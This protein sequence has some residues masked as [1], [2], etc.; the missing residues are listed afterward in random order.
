[1]LAGNDERILS[2]ATDDQ[3]KPIFS[4]ILLYFSMKRA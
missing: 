4:L 1:M 2:F 3:L